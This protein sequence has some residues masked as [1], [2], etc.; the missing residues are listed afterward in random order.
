LNAT[1]D[2]LARQ[3]TRLRRSARLARDRTANPVEQRP[4]RSFAPARTKIQAKAILGALLGRT[5]VER[6][7]QNAFPAQDVR[8]THLH[9]GEFHGS[10]LVMMAFLSS[11]QDPTF[12]EAHREMVRVAPE[13]IIEWLRR[14]GNFQL[15]TPT[16][17]RRTFRRWLRDNIIVA[18]GVIFGFGLAVGW[19]LR[20]FLNG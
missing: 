7:R 17:N 10:E 16:K 2:A 5:A 13:T 19:L 11:Y 8:S 9:T 4:I 15:P 12:G 6:I 3:H 14:R 18:C 1:V 20:M